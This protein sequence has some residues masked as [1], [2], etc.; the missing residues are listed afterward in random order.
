[1]PD[2]SR[3]RRHIDDPA[4]LPLYHARGTRLDQGHRRTEIDRK[5]VIDVVVGVVVRG[6]RW[7]DP[8]IIHEDINRPNLVDYTRNLAIVS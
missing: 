6:Q 4:R 2:L 8:G 3:K 7:Q 5:D 1:M